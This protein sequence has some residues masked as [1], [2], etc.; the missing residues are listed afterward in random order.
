MKTRIFGIAMTSFS[1]VAT[2]CGVAV[3]ESEGEGA[4]ID[5]TQAALTYEEGK[6]GDYAA[7]DGSST[8]TLRYTC[9]ALYSCES[10]YIYSCKAGGQC[11][12]PGTF[13]GRWDINY[14]SKRYV[15]LFQG[16]TNSV[17]H[18]YQITDGPPIKLTA[19]TKSSTATGYET[20][21]HK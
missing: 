2:G 3:G 11:V 6:A 14:A 17:F 15:R 5:S 18:Y 4:A 19:L 9:A 13:S 8:L 12:S 16:S 1:L 10:T 20:L 7:T 21:L